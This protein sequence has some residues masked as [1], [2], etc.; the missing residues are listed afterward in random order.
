MKNRIQNY[1]LILVMVIFVPLII[2]KVL[3]SY[4]TDAYT[5]AGVALIVLGTVF[6]VIARFQLGGSFSVKAEARELVTHGLYSRIRHPI[7]IFGGLLILG[8]VVCV[9]NILL[10]SLW[11]LLMILQVRRAGREDRVLEEK[12][13]EVYRKYKEGTWF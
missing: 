5:V 13:G 6:T 10:L 1:I 12:F 3:T 2:Q 4:P 11:F 9:R 8:M 7:Y